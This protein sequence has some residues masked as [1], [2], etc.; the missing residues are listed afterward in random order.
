MAEPYLAEIKMFGGNFAP[1]GYAMCDGQLLAIA[2]NDALFTLIGTTY[3][4]DGQTTFALPDMRGRLPLHWGQGPG[5]SF[6]NLGEAAGSEN[7]TLTTNQIPNHS[8]PLTANAGAPNSPTPANSIPANGDMYV[9]DVA[10][11]QFASQVSR[12]QVAANRM[13]T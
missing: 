11:V 5:L 12:R 10:G 3:G 4:G 9:E 1:I 6:R 13:I 7:V 2:Q 8:H